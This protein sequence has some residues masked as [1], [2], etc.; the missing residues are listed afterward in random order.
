[1]NSLAEEGSEPFTQCIKFVSSFHTAKDAGGAWESDS[2][3]NDY[4]WWLART[5]D[6]GWEV[7]DWGY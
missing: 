3:Y 6:G 1:M 4:Q 7:V 5:D 2:D